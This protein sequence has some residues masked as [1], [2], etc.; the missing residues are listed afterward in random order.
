MAAENLVECGRFEQ[1]G[2]RRVEAAVKRLGPR[3]FLARPGTGQRALPFVGEER[4]LPALADA[5]FSEACQS[6]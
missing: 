5:L 3:A 2:V 6:P 1:A 4:A